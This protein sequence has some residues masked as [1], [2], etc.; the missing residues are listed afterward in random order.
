LH[1]TNLAM[2]KLL[3]LGISFLIGCLLATSQTRVDSLLQLFNKAPENHKAN[4]LLELSFNTRKDTS[5]SNLYARQALK[6]AERL[7]QLPEQAKA[8]YYFGETHYFSND[9]SK[10]IPYYE[11]SIPLFEQLKDT[12][13]L[14]N[15]YNS[16]G[17]CYHTLSQGENAIKNLIQALKLAEKDKEY[18]AEILGNIAMAH[19]KMGNNRHAINFFKKAVAINQ[20][21]G[22]SISLAI[23]YNGIGQAYSLIHKPDS[24]IIY[25]SHARHLFKKTYKLNYEGIALANLAA[26]YIEYPD[27]LEKAMKC[28]TQAQ[29][30]FQKLGIE[31][32]Q[33]DI[34][35]TTGDILIRQN[36]IEQ[37]IDAFNE[38]LRLSEKFNLGFPLKVSNYGD[39]SEAY[40]KQGS[41]KLAL[42][43]QKL[44]KQYTDSLV[45]K[46]KYKQ[47][48]NLEKQYET[49][50]RQ[51]EII[52]LEARQ[53]LTDVELR[54]N[55]QLKILGFVTASLLL[56]FVFFVLIRYFDKTKLNRLLEQKNKKIKQSE[57][58]LRV[59][60]ASKNK[61]FSII[62]HDL[63]NPFHTVMGYSWLLS[64]DYERFTEEERRKFASDIH[65]S[66]NNIF[67]LL[68]NLLEWS[69]S[70][71]GRLVFT[72][73]EIEFKRV[74]ENSVSVLRS[75][76]D[77]KNIAIK[78]NYND[79][80][81]LFADPLMIETVLRNLINNAVKFT[82]EDGLIEIAA[83]QIDGHISICVK[84]S[85]IG[86]SAEDA[87][88]LF[89]ID[90][91]VKRK[92]TNDED[93][94]GLGLILCKEF[95]DKN[96]GTIWVNS[97]PGKGS[98][99]FFTVPAKTE[100]SH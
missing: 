52:R 78:F 22:D 77:H 92:G 79:D 31:Q 23:N 44:Y 98:S 54:K 16:V 89:Q 68:Q 38:S 67:R 75:L 4:L 3:L 51:N 41:Y 69:R 36:K 90:S 47:I 1:I 83:N 70:Q 66:T 25:L 60:N 27:S 94:S 74:V 64:K 33:A 81:I 35:Q 76:A 93:G 86:I 9:F 97:V 10:A 30:M 65:H 72:P 34:L 55:K 28:L 37:A 100:K 91:T 8:I 50:K 12:F 56:I 48:I 87:R 17:L 42:N 99:F 59:L 61:F 13:Q 71:T 6:L 15:C 45:Q 14:T 49:E 73:Q 40:E 32:Y 29:N 5:K 18:T 88:N 57:N 21:I 20:S 96:N 2:K 26:Q 62:A 84:D 85:G 46:E 43:Y 80:L 95:V 53:E 58:E 11:K 19:S 63:K 7:K 24:S 82:P 39:L